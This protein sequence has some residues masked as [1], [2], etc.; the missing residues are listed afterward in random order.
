LSCAEYALGTG[1][2]VVLMS[3][4]IGGYINRKAERNTGLGVAA[5]G[6]SGCERNA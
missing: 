3:T 4:R 6:D 5:I 1:G 2:I